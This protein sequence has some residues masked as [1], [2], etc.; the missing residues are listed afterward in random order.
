MR[1]KDVMTRYPVCCVSDDTAQAVAQTLRNED[2]GSMPVVTDGESQ[3]LE[4][5][6]TDRD[7]CCSI[8]AAGLDPKTTPVGPFVTRDPVI[9]RPEQSLDSCERLMQTHRIRRIPVVDDEARCIGILSQADLARSEDAPKVHM[10]VAEISRPSL[11]I[12]MPAP[13]TQ[14][15]WSLTT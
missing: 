6:I 4:G 9:C 3:R 2:I 13:S 1:V 10:T 5:I 7:L 12:I 8:I 14:S 15:L 11:A